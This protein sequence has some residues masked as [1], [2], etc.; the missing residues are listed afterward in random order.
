[1]IV[2]TLKLRVGN[3]RQQEL[4]QWLWRLTGVYNWGI[5]KIAK[6]D[7]DHTGTLQDW[8]LG[9]VFPSSQY[10]SKQREWTC[11]V[12]GTH[13]DRDTNSARVVDILGAGT[14]HKE[15]SNGLN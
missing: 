15:A 9:G 10:R 11:A 7:A 2:R 4:N 14:A 3:K 5:S 13:H 8:L 1:M 6:E 12:C